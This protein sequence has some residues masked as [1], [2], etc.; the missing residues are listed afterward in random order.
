MKYLVHFCV[1]AFYSFRVRFSINLGGGS[2][3]NYGDVMTRIVDI[4][5]DT[6]EAVT[7]PFLQS[8]TWSDLDTGPMVQTLRVE[9]ITPIIGSSDPG[10]PIVY[11]NIFRAAGEDYEV[12]GYRN[13]TTFTL[14]NQMNLGSKFS[15]KFPAINEGTS[16][17]M[18]N[19]NVMCEVI[20]SVSDLVKKPCWHG[21]NTEFFPS[22]GTYLFGPYH[23]F[24]RFFMYWR[25]GR[26]V[27][28]Y[29]PGNTTTHNDGW[30]LVNGSYTNNMLENGWVP[31]YNSA[32]ML[33]QQE[34]CLIPYYSAQPYWPSCAQSTHIVP[35]CY[36]FQ[37]LDAS[38]EVSSPD[39][40]AI[41]GADDFVYMFPVLWGNVDPA[42]KAPANTSKAPE[43]K[44]MS[45]NKILAS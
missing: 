20:D 40:I 4:K 7:V 21:S 5:G 34:G 18:T 29:H 14:Q 45:N 44:V 10:A 6:W 24:A 8:S 9:L 31:A 28:H 23:Y 11:V 16:Q 17:S 41:S 2:P 15:E 1:P 39:H 35:S 27:R 42:L 25:G 43:A 32:T 19:G 22:S 30:Y 37:P 12:S 36:D 38:L 26:V 13:P 33:Y 3:V